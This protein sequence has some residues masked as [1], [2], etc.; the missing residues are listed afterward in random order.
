MNPDQFNKF[1]NHWCPEPFHNESFN[2]RL[3]RALMATASCVDAYQR[4][5]KGETIF[6]PID[7]Y[8]TAYP[9]GGI[10]L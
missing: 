8:P 1:V 4:R 10:G 5:D 6:K 7:S 3:V 2:N 9:P